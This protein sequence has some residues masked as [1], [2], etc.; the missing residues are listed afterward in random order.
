MKKTVSI[1]LVCMFLFLAACGIGCHKP[2]EELPYHADLIGWT[3]SLKGD[4]LYKEENRINIKYKNKEYNPDD[5]N[6]KKN[7]YDSTLPSYRIIPVTEEML[8]T[9]V[10]ESVPDVDLETK[11]LLIVIFSAWGSYSCSFENV[12]LKDD[13]LEITIRKKQW[14]PITEPQIVCAVIVLDKLSFSDTTIKYIDY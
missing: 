1:F 5:P 10:F 6:S 3:E 2:Q 8:S 4:F 14:E 11:T 7:F 13:V 9:E 12:E